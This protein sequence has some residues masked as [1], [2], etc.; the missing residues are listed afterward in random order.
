MNPKIS[1]V[2]SSAMR[3]LAKKLAARNVCTQ[4]QIT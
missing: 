3:I 1:P 2:V 4:I